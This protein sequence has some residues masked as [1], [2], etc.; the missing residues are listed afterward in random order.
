MQFVHYRAVNLWNGPGENGAI[1]KRKEF[2]DR[3]NLVLIYNALVHA[4]ASSL[5]LRSLG[6]NR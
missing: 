3:N 5:L 6:S 1:K 4:A 2:V